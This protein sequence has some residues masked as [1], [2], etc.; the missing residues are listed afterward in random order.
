M[1]LSLVS[2]VIIEPKMQ[3]KISYDG[4]RVFMSNQESHHS[5]FK[6][7]F[8]MN[9]PK[10]TSS[11]KGNKLSLYNVKISEKIDLPRKA[12]KKSKDCGVCLKK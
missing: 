3:E 10:V 7:K 2:I 12:I 8:A 6:N 9:G 4:I 1:I 5:L 11:F